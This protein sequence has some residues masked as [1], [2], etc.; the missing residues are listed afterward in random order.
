MTSDE[1]KTTINGKRYQ[2]YDIGSGN[3]AGL[4]LHGTAGSKE[5]MLGIANKYSSLFRC[6][7]PDLPGN[8]GLECNEKLTL[9]Y[10]SEYLGNLLANLKIHELF[11]IGFSLGGLVGLV[12]CAQPDLPFKV[13][14]LVIWS[15][16]ILG[17]KKGLTAKSKFL[18]DL[19]SYTPDRFGNELKQT[20]ILTK[21]SQILGLKLGNTELEA[22]K[23]FGGVGPNNYVRILK[24]FKFK[25]LKLIPS[26]YVFGTQDPLVINNNYTFIRDNC[27]NN[28]KALL[29]DRGGHFGTKDGWKKSEE[30]IANFVSGTIG[31]E[32]GI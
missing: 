10:I 7:V 21:G 26:L 23:N 12:F 20:P 2:Y 31:A 18:F 32:G 14:S 5:T 1:K 11:I 30:V 29:I 15:A 28:E 8:N 19:L 9:K 25:H 17:Y 6:I 13:R 4:F 27:N 22:V 16:P 3:I 24:D